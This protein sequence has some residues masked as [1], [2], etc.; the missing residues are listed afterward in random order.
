MNIRRTLAVPAIV[1]AVLA[2]GSGIAATQGVGTPTPPA[3]SLPGCL[4]DGNLICGLPDTPDNS[5]ARALAWQTWDSGQGWRWLRVDP[6]KELRVD[7]TGYSLTRPAALTAGQVALPGADGVF[8][9]FT[10]HQ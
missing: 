1:I 6:T 10:A 4:T 5:D 2:A 3:H 8:Y 9:V 7:V